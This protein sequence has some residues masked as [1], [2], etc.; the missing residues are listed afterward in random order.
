M[1][2]FLGTDDSVKIEPS[3]IHYIE[4][5]NENP[6]SD[7]IMCIVAEDLLEKFNIEEQDG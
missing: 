3:Q 5:V 6:D 7:E 2:S 1:R 4:L